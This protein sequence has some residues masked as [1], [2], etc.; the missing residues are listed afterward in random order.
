MICQGRTGFGESMNYL[1]VEA[2]GGW[3]Y[4]KPMSSYSGVQGMVSDGTPLPE[5]P[6]HQQARQMDGEALAI[7]ESRSPIVPAEEG[8]NDVRIVQAIMKSSQ[9]GRSRIV[10]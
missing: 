3:Y 7:K 6:A 2:T 1:S 5:D 4:L 10:L 9:E 8:I